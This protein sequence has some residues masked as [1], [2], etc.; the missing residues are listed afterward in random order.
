GDGTGGLLVADILNVKRLDAGGAVIQTYDVAGEDSWFSL[1]LDPNGTSFWSGNIDSANIYKFNIATGAVEASFNTGTGSGTIFGICLKGELTAAG[2]LG[3]RMTGGG[4][5]SL[6]RGQ[7]VTFGLELHCK[8]SDLP[9]NLEV[10]WSGNRFH[11]ESLDSSL[12]T[13]NPEI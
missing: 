4:N 10:N 5:V 3:G 2:L 13:D 9:N 1:N 6:G 7:P 12:C 11:L 8:K